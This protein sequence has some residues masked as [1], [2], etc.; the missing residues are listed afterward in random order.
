MFMLRTQSP[1][2]RRSRLLFI[3]TDANSD[4]AH[5]RELRHAGEACSIRIHVPL[6]H[7]VLRVHGSLVSVCIDCGGCKGY[8][9]HEFSV[10]GSCFPEFPCFGPEGTPHA[11]HCAYTRPPCGGCVTPNVGLTTHTMSLGLTGSF[12]QSMHCSGI[13]PI[14]R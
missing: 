9:G 12:R 2:S 13:I 5:G 6:S 14:Y 11:I 3:A 7:S 8:G 4:N 10:L 1:T